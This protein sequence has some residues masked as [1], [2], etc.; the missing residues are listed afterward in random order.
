MKKKLIHLR[1]ENM[2]QLSEINI[3]DIQEA[4]KIL[5]ARHEECMKV[6]YVKKYL[7]KTI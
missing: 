4:V 1:E 7:G 2:P 6:R 3:S 5:K